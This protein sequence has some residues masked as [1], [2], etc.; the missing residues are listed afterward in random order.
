MSYVFHQFL[1]FIVMTWEKNFMSNLVIYTITHCSNYVTTLQW[2]VFISFLVEMVLV[3]TVFSTNIIDTILE[4]MFLSTPC[5]PC[6]LFIVIPSPSF[7]RFKYSLS[8]IDDFL[9]HTLVYLLKLGSKVFDIFLVYK[10]FVEK[11]LDI[12]YKSE[13]QIMRI[14]M[15]T[16]NSQ[17]DATFHRAFKCNILFHIHHNKMELLKEIISI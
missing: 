2:L 7:S 9:R 11:N 17:L 15:F 8:F 10:A 5:T 16:I 13:E 4:N 6:I 3:S 12:N 14:N 1:L